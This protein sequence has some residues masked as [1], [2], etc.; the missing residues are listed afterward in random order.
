[1]IEY[2]YLKGRLKGTQKRKL[3]QLLDMLYTP[4]EIANELGFGK[5][6]FYRVYIPAGCPHKREENGHLWING[7]AF[8]QWYLE[9]YPKVRIAENEV[10]C[11]T[12]KGPVPIFQP[13]TR[14]KGTYVYQAS[15][16]PNCGRH[17]VK[18]LANERKPYDQSSKQASC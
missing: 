13:E 18:A 1:M 14:Q 4:A 9:R 11:L 3:H 15:T 5:R 10:Y 16:C 2:T 7:T 12:C 6:Q 17:L 8:R